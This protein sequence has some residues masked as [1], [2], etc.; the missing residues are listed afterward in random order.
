MNTHRLPAVAALV[1]L[2]TLDPLAVPEAA[3]AGADPIPELHSDLFSQAELARAREVAA[4][5]RQLQESYL[6]GAIDDD[7]IVLEP[8]IVEGDNSLLLARLRRALELGMGARRRAPISLTPADQHDLLLARKDDEQFFRGPSAGAPTDHVTS[9]VDVLAAPGAIVDA[10][11]N[12][13]VGD[14]FRAP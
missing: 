3:A 1:L 11:R 13:R 5:N 10:F 2:A 8:Y 7:I 9:G 6:R 4:E 14:L 12:R